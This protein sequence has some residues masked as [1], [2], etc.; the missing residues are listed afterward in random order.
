MRTE[1]G[2]RRT[3]NGFKFW[4]GREIFSLK[5]VDILFYR[6]K[7]IVFSL[8]L[9]VG[10]FFSNKT[11]AQIFPPN[12]LCVQ[13]DTL[14]WELPNNSCGSFNN[15]SIFTSSNPTGPFN[16]LTTIT[17]QAQTFFADPNPSGLTLSL[18]HISEPT[19]PY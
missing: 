4:L 8:V 2:K 15:Y 19:R 16:L 10:L 3:A 5:S 12:L 7:K 9:M 17:N 14:F 1:N 11:T 6:M 18:I 13:S